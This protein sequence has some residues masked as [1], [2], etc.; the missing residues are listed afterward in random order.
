[1]A[2]CQPLYVVAEANQDLTV[3]VTVAAD[4]TSWTMTA[5]LRANLGTAALATKTVG[6]GISNTP[7]AGSSTVVVSF[8]A[9]DLALAPGGYT[10]QLER[11]NSGLAYPIIDPSTFRITGGDGDDYPQL[12]N[13]SDYLAFAGYSETVSDADAKALLSYISAAETSI[14][15]WCGR[16]FN[17]DQ[18]TEYPVGTWHEK[19]MLRETPVATTS[20]DIRVDFSRGF[21]STT[22]LTAETDYFL[23][24]DHTGKSPNGILHRIGRVWEGYRV[25]PAGQLSYLKKPGRGMI[26]ATYFGGFT[27]VPDDLRVA[28]FQVVQQRLGARAQG[29]DLQSESGLNYAYSKGPWDDEAKSLGSV[30]QVITRYRRGDVL[31]G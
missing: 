29:H 6:S 24:I 20:M 17:F 13:L 10:W 28:V 26:K 2:F 4:T 11:T 25:R 21:A 23:D 30:Q 19:T 18:Y 9:A 8:S 12:T 27:L 31:V 16:K 3:T 1:M 22:A 7:G 15:D 5:T 14:R